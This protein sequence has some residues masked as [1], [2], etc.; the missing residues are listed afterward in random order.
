LSIKQTLSLISRLDQAG[1]R[2]PAADTDGQTGN[3]SRNVIVAENTTLSEPITTF[4]NVTL[5]LNNKA[6]TYTGSDSPIEIGCKSGNGF[7]NRVT[8]RNGTI[9]CPYADYPWTWDSSHTAN[10]ANYLFEDLEITSKT[11]HCNCVGPGDGRLYFPTFNRIFCKGPGRTIYGT[12]FQ[13]TFNLVETINVALVDYAIDLVN[14]GNN[15]F[16]GCWIEPLGVKMY[17][18]T[19][20]FCS[21]IWNSYNEPITTGVMFSI[22]G[23]QSCLTA[24]S[25]IN[26]VNPNLRVSVTGGARIEFPGLPS[27]QST[28]GSHPAIDTFDDPIDAATLLLLQQSYLIDG[29][30]RIL[31][32]GGSLSGT[33]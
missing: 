32:S 24:L 31:W 1:D 4:G 12:P 25:T 2:E 27:V 15:N 8:I 26:F 29:T 3:K 10:A 13:G 6:L 22:D 11:A 33:I 14:A 5:D 19:G 30:S 21:N 7:T 23:T 9:Y 18:Q 20:A 17:R 28:G 16:N